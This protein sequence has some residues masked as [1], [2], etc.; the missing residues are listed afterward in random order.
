M[1]RYLR[2]LT[3]KSIGLELTA[4]VHVETGDVIVHE[5]LLNT[6]LLT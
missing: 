3:K 5:P 4:P 1:N 6:A 2:N